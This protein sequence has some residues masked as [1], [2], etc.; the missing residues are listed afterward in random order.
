MIEKILASFSYHQFALFCFE[1]FDLP[2]LLL[3]LVV[4]SVIFF[5]EF[6]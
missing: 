3:V 4:E 5:G 2:D 6:A 1:E